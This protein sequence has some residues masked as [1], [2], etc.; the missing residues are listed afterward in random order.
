[1]DSVLEE[2]G[3]GVKPPHEEV[4]KNRTSPVRKFGEGSDTSGQR[5]QF[6]R[7]RVFK[8]WEVVFVPSLPYFT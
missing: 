8:A 5:F 3:E 4:L 6:V 1:M 2:K 7:T